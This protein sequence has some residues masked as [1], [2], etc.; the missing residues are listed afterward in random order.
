MSWAK[1]LIFG[2][3]TPA[4]DMGA[5]PKSTRQWTTGQDGMDK[6]EMREVD[7]PELGE[8]DVLVKIAAVSLNYRDTEG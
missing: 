4:A 2:R 1:N 5:T 6:L 8:G 7:L 3:N